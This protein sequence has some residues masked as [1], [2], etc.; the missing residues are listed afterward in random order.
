MLCA[1]HW[2]MSRIITFTKGSA[3]KVAESLPRLRVSPS[4][5]ALTSTLLNL[6]VKQA[7]H[8]LLRDMTKAVLDGLE[9]AILGSKPKAHWAQNFCVILVLCICIEAVQVASDSFAI[10]AL[11]KDPECGLSRLSI[12]QALD[13]KLFK[14]LTGLFHM[15]YKT[16]RTKGNHK[17]QTGFN[18]IRNGLVVYQDEGITQQM[19]DL[20]NEVRQIMTAHGKGPSGISKQR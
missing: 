8:S 15:A 3:E 11:C 13:K 14:E 5:Q 7:M 2:F 10:A 4:P 1:M 6:Q 12:C 17:S 9:K 19:V 16:Y 18:P 20:V